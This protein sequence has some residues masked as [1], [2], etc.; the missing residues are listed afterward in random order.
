MVQEVRRVDLGSILGYQWALL[1]LKA[2]PVTG[3][4]YVG[5]HNT[6]IL[7]VAPEDPNP[8]WLCGRTWE[9]NGVNTGGDLMSAS[10][11]SIEVSSSGLVI[12]TVGM[13]GRGTFT[14][15]PDEAH[16]PWGV[17]TVRPG[18]TPRKIALFQ[19]DKEFR[20]HAL[21]AC[22]VNEDESFLLL[23]TK[24]SLYKVTFDEENLEVSTVI[25]YAELRYCY[26]RCT[27]LPNSG[28]FVLLGEAQNVGLVNS[29]LQCVAIHMNLVILGACVMRNRHGSS[30]AL[31]SAYHVRAACEEVFT[32]SFRDRKLKERLEK[33]ST[34]LWSKNILI[35][36][37]LLGFDQKNNQLVTD[38]DSRILTW[39]DL[40]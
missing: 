39:L 38:V 4:V 31:H 10:I 1:A 33:D 35:D 6:P 32:E 36:I 15:S 30:V 18:E 16:Y 20:L 11:T 28:M 40:Y 14:P 7:Y 23:V 8:R 34:S 9:E 3:N 27:F 22:A 19:N 12:F 17:Y 13:R 5:G 37:P 29:Q 2:C 24:E 26:T 25:Q 21:Q